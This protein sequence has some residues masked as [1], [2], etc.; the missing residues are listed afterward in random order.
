MGHFLILP[1]SSIKYPM[2][3]I[4]WE[5]IPNTHS[6]KCTPARFTL[7]KWLALANGMLAWSGFQNGHRGLAFLRSLPLR[8][9]ATEAAADP[10]MFKKHDWPGSNHNMRMPVHTAC[11]MPFTLGMVCYILAQ[12]DFMTGRVANIPR[13]L[14]AFLHC[15]ILIL[16]MKTARSD[17]LEGMSLAPSGASSIMGTDISHLILVSSIPTMC[18]QEYSRSV[19][20][21]HQSLKMEG[22]KDRRKERRK[23][24]WKE[25][26]KDSWKKGR[27]EGRNQET[28]SRLEGHSHSW[29]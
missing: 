15:V 23:D 13:E 14:W 28:C 6:V 1:E 5:I 3:I 27:K 9:R 19:Q 10:K 16:I 26:R 2:D 29:T 20:L 12:G 8:M 18:L 24:K 21:Q 7:V 22:K 11:Y 25:G 4:H 17:S